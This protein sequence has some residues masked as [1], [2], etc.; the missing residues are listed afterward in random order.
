MPFVDIIIVT[1]GE[2]V[3]V[4]LDTVRAACAQDYARSQWRVL[5]ADDGNDDELQAALCS[6]SK[7]LPCQLLYH[8]R[9]GKPGSKTGYKAG[10]MNAALAHLD[11]LSESTGVEFCAFL[12]CD[13]IVARDFLRTCMGHLLTEPK[14]GVAIIPQS[15]YNLPRNDPLYQSKHIH[16]YLDQVQ[17]DSLSSAWETG[18]GV[19]FRRQAIKDI[20]GFNEWVLMEDVVAGMFLNGHGWQTVYCHE[21]LQWGLVPDTLAGHIAQRRKWV[22]RRVP[23]TESY[24]HA[25]CANRL[26]VHCEVLCLRALASAENYL[27]SSGSSVS[28]KFGRQRQD[29]LT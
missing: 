28:C 24:L 5:V 4:I 23:R 19:V 16:N 27:R 25:D 29:I 22:R 12:D 21:Q 2:D 10:N 6:L 15:F 9:A 14:A 8:R 7:D 26:S 13:M 20:G 3:D 17:R 1:C 11:S 18:P